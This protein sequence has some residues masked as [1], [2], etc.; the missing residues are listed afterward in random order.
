ME[1]TI[2][3]K[4]NVLVNNQKSQSEADNKTE[5][6]E[7]ISSYI[8]IYDCYENSIL[9]VNKAFETLTGYNSHE[10]N[11]DFLTGMIHPED[12]PYF[13]ASE[14]RGLNFTNKLLF[15]EHFK[16]LLSYS[17]RIKTKNGSYIRILQQCQALEV[18]NS[19]HLTKTLVI[20]K[21]IADFDV[22]P[23]NDYKILDKSNNVYINEQNS[24]NL[25]ERELE[26]LNLIK[27]GYNSERIAFELKISTNTVRT[28]RK[29]ILTKAKSNSFIEL[30]KKI[31]ISDFE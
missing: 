11:L 25:S 3:T 7:Q 13:F 27:L 1:D 20:H 12:V 31:S 5:S 8:F 21:R 26:I 23:K 17:Y 2:A 28:H 24:Y 9:Y 30:I 15:N 16:Y 19:G 6:V 22:L 18:N 4:W 29:N 10:F 14:E